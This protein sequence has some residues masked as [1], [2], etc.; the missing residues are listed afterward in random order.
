MYL[1]KFLSECMMTIFRPIKFA[2]LDRAFFMT[3]PLIINLRKI[4]NNC[5]PQ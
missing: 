3:G 2:A 5:V 4:T 1:T